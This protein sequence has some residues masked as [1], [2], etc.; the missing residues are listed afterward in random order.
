[1]KAGGSILS[2]PEDSST[3]CACGS[4]KAYKDCCQPAHNGS[5][6]AALSPTE[7]LRARFSSFVYGLSDYIMLSAHP[8]SDDYVAPD[9]TDAKAGTLKERP[10]RSKRGVWS[11]AIIRFTNDYEF[12]N[13][14]LDN[15]ETECNPGDA[16]F[17]EV[18]I[19]LDRVGRGARMGVEK[20]VEKVKFKKDESGTW[21]FLGS[22]MTNKGTEVST[23]AG[24]VVSLPGKPQRMMST[25]R[26]GVEAIAR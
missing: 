16:A 17:C 26:A 9:A 11:K 24:E 23:E 14:K 8:Q 7:Q 12:S 3:P 20:I 2:P 1:M 13:L 6:K 5:N 18:N 4:T 25:K 10:G 22:D 15:E 19:T 21:L